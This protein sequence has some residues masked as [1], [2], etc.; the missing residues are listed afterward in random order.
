MLDAF[1]DA[2]ENALTI[3]VNLVE[4]EL[5]SKREL[6]QLVSDGITLAAVAEV[7]GVSLAVLEGI[8]ESED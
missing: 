1:T 6:A 5:P 3:S 8:A 4:G 2:V 7:T